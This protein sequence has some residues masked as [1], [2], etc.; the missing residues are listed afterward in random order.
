VGT[1]DAGLNSSDTVTFVYEELVSG[2]VVQ[3]TFVY[4]IQN[5]A[6]G[7]PSLFRSED[8]GTAMEVTEGIENLQV[9]YGEDVDE[10]YVPDHYVN[11]ASVADRAKIVALKFTITARTLGEN[12][13]KGGGKLTRTFSS[14]VVLRNRMP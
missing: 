3:K 8:G 11:W 10:D 14:T 12:V 1:N 13:A 4:S 6:S 2:S 7:G 5:G 9:Q